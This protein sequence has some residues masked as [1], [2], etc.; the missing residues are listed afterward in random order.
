MS[1]LD[2]ISLFL[3]RVFGNVLWWL[4]FSVA[5]EFVFRPIQ[6]EMALICVSRIVRM[7]SIKAFEYDD[8]ECI[9][10]KVAKTS[11][12]DTGV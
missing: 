1:K 4:N 8:L 11:T 5:T 12:G 10:S 2:K 9:A 7:D 6:F 3:R